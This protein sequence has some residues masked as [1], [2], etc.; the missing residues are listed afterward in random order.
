MSGCAIA[1]AVSRLLPTVAARVQTQV[2]SCGVL[3]WT[4]VAL[5][6][7]FSENFGFPCQSTF[8][9]L[10]HNH[11]H[12]LRGWHNKPGVAIVSIASQTPPPQKFIHKKV[13]VVSLHWFFSLFVRV[14]LSLLYASISLTEHI[15]Y[16]LFLTVLGSTSS[17]VF[18]F[19]WQI[20]VAGL[21]DHCTAY[22]LLVLLVYFIYLY[23]L[24]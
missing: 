20:I 11:L 13:C 9:L 23:W 5:G 10:F 8:H 17:T 3:W 22:F 24:T 16:K 15:F 14:Y 2:W 6:Q 7:V 21:Y 18:L 12:Y 4:K 1:Q 19:L